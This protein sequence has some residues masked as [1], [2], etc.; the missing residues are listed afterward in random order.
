MIDD[1]I[2]SLKVKIEKLQKANVEVVHISTCI[3]GRCEHYEC[4]YLL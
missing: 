3:R 4:F 1:E 2:E